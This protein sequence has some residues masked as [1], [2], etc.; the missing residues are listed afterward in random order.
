MG[1]LSWIA[2]EDLERAVSVLQEQAENSYAEAGRRMV[3]NVV[4]PFSAAVIAST[5][6]PNS[7]AELVNLHKISSALRGMS[8]AL[9]YFHQSVLGSVEGW[10]NHDTGYDLE[11]LGRKIIAEIKNKHNTLSGSKIPGVVQD[12]EKWVQAKG[13][14]WMAYLVMVVPRRPERYEKQPSKRVYEIDGASFYEMATGSETALQDLFQVSME[15][16]DLSPSF[17]NYCRE[18]FKSSL[19]T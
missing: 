12:L 10:R 11:H 1:R 7:V 4:D 17:T 16:L 18:V 19:P 15:I 2:D 6:R 14:D 3:R 13:R 8:N 5:I 9:G